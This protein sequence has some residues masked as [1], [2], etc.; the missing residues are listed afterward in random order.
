MSSEGLTEN[1]HTPKVS[2]TLCAQA[3]ILL[4]KPAPAIYQAAMQLLDIDDPKQLVAIGDSLEHD[5]AGDNFTDHLP[6]FTSIFNICTSQ[7]MLNL[8]RRNGLV[9]PYAAPT[10]YQKISGV[11]TL[12]HLI[13]RGSSCWM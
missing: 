3:C 7:V 1:V 10:A 2:Y 6:C 11:L 5:I 13:C 8:D 12:K 4:G 9:L